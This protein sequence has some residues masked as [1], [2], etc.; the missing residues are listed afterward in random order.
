MNYIRFVAYYTS[1][2]IGQR[3][4][5]KLFK[6]NLDKSIFDFITVSDEAFAIVI[7]ENNKEKWVQQATTKKDS[8]H[9]G[10]AAESDESTTISTSTDSDVPPPPYKENKV[11]RGSQ[12]EKEPSLRRQLESRGKR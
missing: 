5:E 12:G 9:S 1:Q 6:E 4:L 3:K 7:L 11:D 8:I 10:R 2:L